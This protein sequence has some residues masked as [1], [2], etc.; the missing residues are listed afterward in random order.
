MYDPPDDKTFLRLV[1]V[2]TILI[3]GAIFVVVWSVFERSPEGPPA[4]SFIPT[5]CH[6]TSNR[7]SMSLEA[8]DGKALSCRTVAKFY[9]PQDG[10]EWAR[11]YGCPSFDYR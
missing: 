3:T 5:V 10:A 4:S 1:V 6:I 2:V 9:S 11:I 7:Y 8:C